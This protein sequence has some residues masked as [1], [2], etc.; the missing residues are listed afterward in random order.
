M[1]TKCVQT[2]FYNKG[3]MPYYGSGPLWHTTNIPTKKSDC[4]NYW[5]AYLFFVNNFVPGGK[6]TKVI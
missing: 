1:N 2:Y 4:E 5:Y 3:I 6:G